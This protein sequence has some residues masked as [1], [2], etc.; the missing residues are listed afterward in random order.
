M[1]PVNG[2]PKQ[3]RFKSSSVGGVI[4]EIGQFAMSDNTLLELFDKKLSNLRGCVKNLMQDFSSWLAS[5]ADKN[6]TIR[7]IDARATE[8]ESQNEELDLESLEDKGSI[9]ISDIVNLMKQM[10]VDI[11]KK[12]ATS[13]EI[14]NM[15]GE[16]RLIDDK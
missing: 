3:Y 8:L 14:L 7:D 15:T 5:F 11:L 12:C 13:T 4:E 16:I 9:G 6:R 2:N 10:Q 1:T